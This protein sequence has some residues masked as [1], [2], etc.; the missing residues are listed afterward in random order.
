MRFYLEAGLMERGLTPEHGPSILVA[1]R[2]LRT[3]L[4]SKGYELEYAEYNGG[5]DY[6]CW[7]GSLAD[8][9]IALAAR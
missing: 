8:G 3:I 4:G 9:L 6:V 1:N 7:R 2:H 5:H